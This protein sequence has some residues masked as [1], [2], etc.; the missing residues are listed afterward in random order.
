MIYSYIITM[1]IEFNMNLLDIESANASIVFIF[2][3]CFLVY[4]I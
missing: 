4:V 1:A 2:F 3:K